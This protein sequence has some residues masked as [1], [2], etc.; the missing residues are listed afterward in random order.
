MSGRPLEGDRS[1]ALAEIARITALATRIETPCGDGRLVWHQWGAGRPVML[2]HGGSGSWTHWIRNVEALAAAGYRVIVPDLPGSGDSDP[3]PDGHDADVI[4]RWLEQGLRELLSPDASLD[5]VAFSFGTIVAV[6]F[7]RDWPARVRRLVLTGPPVLRH[8][9]PPFVGLRSWRDAPPGPARDRVHLHNLRV[10]MCANPAAA[11][12]LAVETHGRNVERD[13]LTKR[14]LA[15][16]S[17]LHDTIRQLRL[18]LHLIAGSL[19]VLYRH[20]WDV[21]HASLDEVPALQSRTLIE[22]AGHWVAYEAAERYNAIVLAL[23][24]D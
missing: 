13:R 22:G 14:R 6:L 17:L 23:L 19:D 15:Q 12:A 10:F 1:Q 3:P 18:P 8:N 9:P 2:L 4:P 5:V 11:D 24:K 7:A 16:T 21:I 20:Q